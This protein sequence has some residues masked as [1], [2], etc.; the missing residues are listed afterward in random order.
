M[1]EPGPQPPAFIPVLDHA[2]RSSGTITA[3]DG[4]SLVA[5][6]PSRESSFRSKTREPIT[7][8]N[9]RAQVDEA[10]ALSDALS[11][12]K[13]RRRPNAYFSPAV[14]AFPVRNEGALDDASSTSSSTTNL[15]HVGRH[16]MTSGVEDNAETTDGIR[17]SIATF[18]ED[19][20]VI[21][22]T[23]TQVKARDLTSQRQHTSPP[24]SAS[25]LEDVFAIA[26]SHDNSDDE[27]DEG[28]TNGTIVD[29]GPSASSDVIEDDS[30]ESSS[31]S[32]N[33]SFKTVDVDTPPTEPE[34]LLL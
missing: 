29:S 16:F 2:G 25:S 13:S 34:Q 8:E 21:I 23:A 24:S 1:T 4:A 18:D 11:R 33:A 30:D 10:I 9:F 17:D 20:E 7:T 22:E 27:G 32:S 31:G 12:V 3:D 6:P 28:S 26:D 14:D 15:D 5:L 19:E